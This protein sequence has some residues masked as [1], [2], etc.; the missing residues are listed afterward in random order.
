MKKTFS[1]L[2]FV[3][4]ATMGV[5]NAQTK[6]KKSK[7]STTKKT[8]TTEVVTSK[9]TAIY[10][11]DKE[12]TVVK[13]T[14]KKVGGQHSGKVKVENGTLKTSENNI[15]GG[16][17][18]VDMNSITCDDIS[19][20]EYNGKLVGHLKN[21]D[22]FNTMNFPHA[23]LEIVKVTNKGNGMYHIEGTL[24]IKGETNKID[25]DAKLSAFGD[26]ITGTAS[27]SFDRTKYNV[28]YGSGLVG[29]AKDKMIYDDITLD[30]EFVA[31][32]R[33]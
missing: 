20:A 33:G 18:V 29:T 28:K 4:I 17:M 9:S 26:K 30:I 12:A 1:I 27:V 2:F 10:Q 16:N 22:F 31:N 32:K 5:V 24:T 19:D 13:W 3:V 21:E 23:I 15:L 25:F 7:K 14:G 8:T 6:A 11:I